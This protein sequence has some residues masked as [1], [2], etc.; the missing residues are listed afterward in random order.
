MKREPVHVEAARPVSTRAVVSGM[1]LGLAPVAA[2]YALLP[3]ESELPE[4]EVLQR[5]DLPIAAAAL[6][7]WIAAAGLLGPSRSFA[8]LGLPLAGALA[9]APVIVAAL[10]LPTPVSNDERAY[11]LQAEMFAAGRLSLPLVEPAEAL[12]WR[13][14]H[15]DPVRGAVYAKYPPG[16][17]LALTPGT[18][19]GMPSATVAL[20]GCLS[21]LLVVAIARR[22]DIATPGAAALLFASSP[23]FLL[24]QASQQSQVFTLPA[25]LAGYLALLHA[26]AGGGRA[27]VHGLALGACAGWIFLARPLTGV[28]FAASMLPGLLLPGRDRAA[29][30]LRALSGA[31]LGGLPFLAALLAYDRALTGSALVTPY[32]LYAAEFSPWDVYPL[33]R[34]PFF[35]APW[36]AVLQNL[37]RQLVRW[38][39]A[40]FGVLGAAGLGF[41]GLWRLRGR[42]GGAGLV[43]AIALPVAYAL[44]WY[45][46]HSAVLGPIYAAE[47]LGLLVVAAALL[48]DDAPP[49]WGKSLP[50]VALA[51]GTALFV[52]RFALVEEH[53]RRRFAPQAVVAASPP[54]RDAVVLLP[55]YHKPDR[56]ERSMNLYTPSRPPLDAPVVYLRQF[57]SR[58]RTRAAIEAFGLSGRAVYRFVPD[59]SGFGGGLEPFDP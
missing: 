52:Y 15:E 43:F 31:L 13:Q 3:T 2:L 10:L 25:A 29:P 38:L 12:R 49:S 35:E 57:D 22:L 4:V 20:A 50:L 51:A 1:V 54:E 59:E 34:S 27:F 17:A 48:L 44:H 56:R 28:V 37:L 23:L 58:A 53:A 47:S 42:D 18:L 6:C 41:W 19:L 40:L 21:V 16:T 14:I 24:L 46:G 33:F 11:A 45:P 26:R 8:K 32:A 36:L 39:P 9:V 30:G 55:R 5:L 7:A